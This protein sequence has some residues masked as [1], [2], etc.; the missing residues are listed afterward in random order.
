MLDQDQETSEAG[1]TVEGFVFPSLNPSKGSNIC[2]GRPFQCG[3]Q[4]SRRGPCL[5][6]E[7]PPPP[8]CEVR[9]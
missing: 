3:A 9:G 2:S 7:G 6:S 1:T 8:W 4:W 5:A